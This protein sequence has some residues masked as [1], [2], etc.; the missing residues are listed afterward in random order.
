MKKLKRIL[1]LFECIVIMLLGASEYNLQKVNAKMISGLRQKP[2]N[3]SVVVYNF[4]DFFISLVRQSLENIQ[5]QNEGKVVFK[6]FDGQGNQAIQNQVIDEIIKREAP[7]ILLV[8]LVNIQATQEVLNLVSGKKDIPVVIFNREPISIDPVKAYKKAFYVGRNSKEAGRL[9]GEILIDLWNNDRSF[10]DKN[11]DGILQYIM[12]QG[13]RASIES[14]ERTEYSV[15][16]IEKAGIKTAQIATSICSWRRD[17]ARD[18]VN[19][20]LLSYSTQIDAII[21]N[22]DEMAIGAIEALQNYGFNKGDKVKTI[23]VVGV[24]ATE[25]AQ[26]LIKK[27]YMAG[28]VIQD[29]YEMAYTAYI[30]GMNILQGKEPLYGTQYKVDETGVAVRLPYARFIPQ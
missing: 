19:S 4:D 27:G 9:Q 2:V 5:K 25:D 17:L 18:A 26:E 20:L 8:N 23:P 14:Q 28:T 24:D 21:V 16:T 13:E 10:I 3:V 7:D 1:V 22:N 29:P 6:F 30:A 11:N 12:L 15:S